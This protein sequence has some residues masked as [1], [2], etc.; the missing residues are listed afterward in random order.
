MT[1]HETKNAKFKASGMLPEGVRL[2]HSSRETPV[3]GVERRGQQSSNF[4]Q[5]S[6]PINTSGG[7]G[8]QR[9]WKGKPFLNRW[10]RISLRTQQNP[11]TVFNN[12]LL[13]IKEET[14]KEAYDELVL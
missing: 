8:R 13:H 9:V 14:L 12:L 6:R 1:K 4:I 7:Q 3:M 10:I 2:S 11:T 5:N